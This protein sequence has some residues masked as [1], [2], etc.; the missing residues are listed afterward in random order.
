MEKSE[1][2][3][4]VEKYKKELMRMAGL[5]VKAQEINN[6]VMEDVGPPVSAYDRNDA[7]QNTN[8][9]INQPQ[10]DEIGERDPLPYEEGAPY[11]GN[12]AGDDSSL[13]TYQ[14]FLDKNKEYGLLKVQAFAA[15]QALPVSGVKVRVSKNFS[16]GEK[17]FFEG[18]TDESGIIDNIK[19]HTTSKL[20]SEHPENVLPYAQYDFSAYHENYNT[21]SANN[22]QVFQD[23]KSIQP[24]RV[25]P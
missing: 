8:T 5:T 6:P 12:A 15:R 20:L 1:F 2:K 3:D 16:D 14:E 23:I 19:L 25:V 4:M 7:S 21:Q 17:V 11:T 9:Q 10:N 13:E 22:I 18:E 24:V